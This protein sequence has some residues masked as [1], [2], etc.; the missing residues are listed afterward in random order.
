MDLSERVERWEKDPWRRWDTKPLIRDLIADWKKRGE[1]LTELTASA[2]E[3]WHHIGSS[4]PG[5]YETATRLAA[6]TDAAHKLLTEAD[7]D[8]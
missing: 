1:A 5:R 2:S 4:L 6:A 7:G 8:R 3:A